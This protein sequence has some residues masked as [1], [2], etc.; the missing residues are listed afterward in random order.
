MVALS[1]RKIGILRRLSKK[2]KK[3]LI[4]LTKATKVLTALKKKS[5][6]DI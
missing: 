3:L 4:A 5:K 2:D 6:N 1:Q